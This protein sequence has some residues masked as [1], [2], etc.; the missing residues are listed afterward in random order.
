MCLEARCNE[1]SLPGTNSS[2]NIVK[3]SYLAKQDQNIIINIKDRVRIRGNSNPASNPVNDST[4]Q[5]PKIGF[6]S[7][8]VKFNEL[9]S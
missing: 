1:T 5:N 7:N 2:N 4:P 8:Q 6:E 3:I 9:L